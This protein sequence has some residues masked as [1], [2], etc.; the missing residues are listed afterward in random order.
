MKIALDV[1]GYEND[2]SEA[3]IAARKFVKKYHDVKII[4]VGDKDKINPLIQEGEFEVFHASEVLTMEESALTALRRT[5]T[6]MFQATSFFANDI[7]AYNCRFYFFKL[8]YFK[9]Y[10]WNF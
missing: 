6:S 9:I 8:L 4:L 3:I 1:M 7:F 5:N 10:P 2:I